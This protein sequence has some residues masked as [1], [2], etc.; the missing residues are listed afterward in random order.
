MINII[1][2]LTP[3]MVALPAIWLSPCDV[4]VKWTLTLI[5]IIKTVMDCDS[6]RPGHS[7]LIY[8]ITDWLPDAIQDICVKL[9]RQI[10]IVAFIYLALKAQAWPALVA[11]ILSAIMTFAFW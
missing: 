5:C 1:G 4:S 7:G 11:G 10:P 3:K 8:R 2:I 9:I 6:S